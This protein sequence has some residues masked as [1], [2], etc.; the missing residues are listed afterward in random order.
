MVNPEKDRNYN[1]LSYLFG[2]L[3][4]IVLAQKILGYM[5]LWGASCEEL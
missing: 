5:L 1:Y 3:L 2:G 4:E